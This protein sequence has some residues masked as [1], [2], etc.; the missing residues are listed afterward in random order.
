M[1]ASIASSICLKYTP[2]RF[3]MKKHWFER[4]KSMQ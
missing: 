1:A 2:S 3:N 4:E